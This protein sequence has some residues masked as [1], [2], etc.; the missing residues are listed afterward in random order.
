MKERGNRE[1]I[2]VATKVASPMGNRPND[3]GLSRHHI[4]AGVEASLRRLQTDYIDLYQAH[5]DDKD[6]PLEETLRAFDDLVKQGKVRYLGASNYSGWRLAKSLWVSDKSNLNRFECLQPVYNLVSRAEYERE[7]EPLCV[8]E[9]VGVIT[10]SSLASGF[11]SGKYGKNKE[12]PGSP[13]AV[14]V[15]RRYMHAKGFT[16]L[17]AV[18]KVA[19]QYNATPSQVAIAWILMRPS[20]TAPIASTTS[21]EQT[22]ELVGSLDLK[23]SPETIAE[24]DKA[25]AWS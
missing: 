23:L 11:L 18:E 20:V 9:N 13:R 25:S 21:V 19:E 8:E 17:E 16:V 15:E 1:A 24:L 14:A 4:M 12:K 7:L 10:Y 3:A 2:I 6:T 5:S 22:K